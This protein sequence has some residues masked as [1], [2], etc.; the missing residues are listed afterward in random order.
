MV[1]NGLPKQKSPSWKPGDQAIKN[2]IIIKC[3][4]QHEKHWSILKAPYLNGWLN[5]SS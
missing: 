2:S 5:N 4:A 1:R 3:T